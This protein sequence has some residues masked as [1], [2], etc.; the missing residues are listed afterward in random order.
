MFFGDYTFAMTKKS[1]V[2]LIIGNCI[3]YENNPG[4]LIYILLNQMQMDLYEICLAKYMELKVY[5][6]T[7]F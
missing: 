2:A 5:L 7:H 4:N 1:M 6:Q 3:F